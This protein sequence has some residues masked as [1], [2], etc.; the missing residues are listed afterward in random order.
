MRTVKYNYITSYQY[1]QWGEKTA[2]A[3][4]QFLQTFRRV[5][6]ERIPEDLDVKLTNLEFRVD[7]RLLVE[8][9]GKKKDDLKFVSNIL[10]E[11]TGE[12]FDSNNV[13]KRRGLFG[14]L[15]AVG[16]VGF[17]V[18]VDVGI[19]SPVKEVLIPLHRLRTQLAGGKDLSTR[20]IC[21]KYGFMNQFPV[22]IEVEKML[23]E[24]GGKPKYE[25]KFTDDFLEQ[26]EE[27]VKSGLDI[28]FTT[29]VSRQMVKK[30]IAKRGHTIDVP[31]IIRIGPLECACVCAKGTNA[32]GIISH[33]GPFLSNCRFSMIRP[34]QL[35]RYWQ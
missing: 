13:P 11:I 6:E 7:D 14:T 3:R 5:L 15:R 35:T 32:P 19:E 24:K 1:Y 27:Y 28:V 26:I 21:K 18:F 8:L 4:A 17:G 30:T 10:K 22:E 23:F 33:I 2:Q 16:K 9:E 20:E 31:Q 12:T 34:A 29:G 25:G